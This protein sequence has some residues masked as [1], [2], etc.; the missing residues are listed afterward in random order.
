M[1]KNQNP[2]EESNLNWT[3]ETGDYKMTVVYVISLTFF[4]HSVYDAC[5][6]NFVRYINSVFM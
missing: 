1:N 5:I 4:D 6:L 3:K 2:V